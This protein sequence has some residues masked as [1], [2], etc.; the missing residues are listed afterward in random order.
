MAKSQRKWLKLGKWE[1][2]IYFTGI[3]SPCQS[4]CYTLSSS[5]QEHRTKVRTTSI[6]M[7]NQESVVFLGL[8]FHNSYNSLKDLSMVSKIFLK[9]LEVII[10]FLFIVGFDVSHMKTKNN[11]LSELYLSGFK[12]NSL[13]GCHCEIKQELL[14]ENQNLFTISKNLRVKNLNL[15]LEK[16]ENEKSAPKMLE[17]NP[18]NIWNI[19]LFSGISSVH[20]S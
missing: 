5:F 14:T 18:A 9:N 3:I 10:F 1:S 20:T 8:F 15:F 12:L 13:E 16:T 2:L 7:Q 6:F 17:K 19:Y 11:M 4:P